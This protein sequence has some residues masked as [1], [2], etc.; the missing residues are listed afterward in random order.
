MTGEEG[1][2]LEAMIK[3]D[4]ESEGKQEEKRKSERVPKEAGG[5]ISGERGPETTSQAC[6]GGWKPGE[7][8]KQAGREP[9]VEEPI[10]V[11]AKVTQQGSPTDG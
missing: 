10:A 9:T 6:G 7:V 2:V 5:P 11:P 4:A 8:M 1:A 3:A